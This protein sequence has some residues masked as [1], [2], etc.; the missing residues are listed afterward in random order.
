[1]LVQYTQISALTPDQKQRLKAT[2]RGA[3][4]EGMPHVQFE[5]LTLS[6]AELASFQRMWEAEQRQGGRQTLFG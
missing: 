1:M 5:G 2:F 3:V 4:L 6:V